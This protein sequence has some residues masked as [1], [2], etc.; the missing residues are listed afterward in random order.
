MRDGTPEVIVAI[1]HDVT[2]E[3]LEQEAAAADREREARARLALKAGRLVPWEVD[4][5]SGRIVAD[6][7]L[8]DMFGLDGDLPASVD[9][10]VARIH[11][12][13]RES[14]LREFGKAALPGGSY[15]ARF[16][17]VHP[18]R[19]TR[20]LV[21]TAEGIVGADGGVRIVGY[22]GDVTQEVAD[23]QERALIADELMHRTKN[24]LATVR[25]IATLSGQGA[26]DVQ[27]FLSTF[28][29]RIMAIARSFG[30]LRGGNWRVVAIDA[31][32]RDCL[33]HL[34]DAHVRI[35]GP[36]AWISAEA[37]QR[38]GLVL[39]EL[40]TNALK[41][42]A[43]SVPEGE[44]ELSW[45]LGPDGGIALEW[46]ERGGPPVAAKGQ[47]FGTKLIA[48][49]TGPKGSYCLSPQGVRWT[50][51]LEVQCRPANGD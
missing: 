31:L 33:S 38:L 5:A 27:E 42:G 26:K 43:L 51:V 23:E 34:G 50:D 25:S 41:Y 28:D 20:W 9:A 1:I 13:D 8:M 36:E 30:Q 10:F 16:R 48:R 14:T 17:V 40:A 45:S 32:A 37:S 35:T 47:G 39:H 6:E 12:D 46:M 2:D 44:V 29:G 49:L 7:Q 15:H 3:R 21:G 19:G 18:L 22:N 4:A 11:P 24:L